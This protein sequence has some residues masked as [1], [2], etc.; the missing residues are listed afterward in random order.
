MYSFKLRSI[1]PVFPSQTQTT[2]DVKE[3]QNK[4]EIQSLIMYMISG[5]ERLLNLHL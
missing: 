1:G 3:K 2:T 5:D 4:I